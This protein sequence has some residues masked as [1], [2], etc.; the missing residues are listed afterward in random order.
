MN[1]FHLDSIYSFLPYFAASETTSMGK[2]KP[3]HLVFY[4]KYDVKV[5][6]DIISDFKWTITQT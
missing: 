2:R 3:D 4:Y 1:I 5:H 6:R